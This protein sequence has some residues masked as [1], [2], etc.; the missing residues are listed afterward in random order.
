M[1]DYLGTADIVNDLRTV[2]K[3]KKIKVNFVYVNITQQID[4]IPLKLQRLH[5]IRKFLNIPI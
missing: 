2:C 3:T 5:K 1:G 4:N